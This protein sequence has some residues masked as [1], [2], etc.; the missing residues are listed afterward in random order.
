MSIMREKFNPECELHLE[1]EA[2]SVPQQIEVYVNGWYLCSVDI[3]DISPEAWAQ[4]KP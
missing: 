1:Y 2:G 4:I 3:A